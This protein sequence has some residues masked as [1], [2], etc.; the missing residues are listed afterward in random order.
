MSVILSQGTGMV[1]V[2]VELPVGSDDQGAPLYD[3]P[4]DIEARAVRVNE[5]V[6]QPDGTQVRSTVTLWIDA[7]QAPLAEQ[8]RVTFAGA[9]YIALLVDELKRLNGE[10]DHLRVRLRE[11]QH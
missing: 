2:S 4:F 9:T 10:V 7:A 5:M 6:L 8:A 3:S 11:E 1:T